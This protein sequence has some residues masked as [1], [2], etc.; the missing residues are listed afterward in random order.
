V[1]PPAV[2]G[3]TPKKEVCSICPKNR[4]LWTTKRREFTTVET[5]STSTSELEVHL[6]LVEIGQFP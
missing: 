4:R 5:V 6:A 1:Q 2:S 3:A